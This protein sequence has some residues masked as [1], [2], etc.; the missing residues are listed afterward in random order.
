MRAL[1]SLLIGAALAGCGVPAIAAGDRNAQA[2]AQ[3]AK[4]LQGRVAG[5]PV[6]CIN[7]STVR[8]STIIDRTAILYRT[9]GGQLYLNTPQTGKESLDD[10]DILLT[11][12]PVSQLCRMDV[13]VLFDRI[14][15]FETGFV[16]LGD[17]V[18]YSRVRKD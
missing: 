9:S 12:N 1:S 4:A 2:E 3:L 11:T 6:S 7:L 18:P 8:S 13:V 14:A 10:D 17:F 15:R 16:S 5:K